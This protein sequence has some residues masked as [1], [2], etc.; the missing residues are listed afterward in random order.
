MQRLK[1]VVRWSDTDGKS[2]RKSYDAEKEAR[3][4][5]DWLLAN[6]APNA[7]VAISMGDREYATKPPEAKAAAPVVPQQD[8]WYDK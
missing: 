3:K 1:F 4:A 6:G 7:D 5:R 8:F 2:H